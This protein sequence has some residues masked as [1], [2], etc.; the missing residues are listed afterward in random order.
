MKVL[1]II[2]LIFCF[3][4]LCVQAQGFYFY[5]AY[6]PEEYKNARQNWAFAQDTN[7]YLFAGNTE[8]LLKYNGVEWQY[9]HIP[10]TRTVRSLA[11]G[12]DGIIYVGGESEFGFVRPDSLNRISYHR[13]SHDS[14]GPFTEIWSTV[15]F[16]DR[17]YF[18]S[19]E[20]IFMLDKGEITVIRSEARLSQ[21]SKAGDRLFVRLVGTGLAEV[22]GARLV[23]V[24]GGEI[25]SDESFFTIDKLG[26][27]YYIASV[28]Y[29]LTR[30]RG[31]SFEI[32]DT[33]GS[34][35]LS[36][37]DIYRSAEDGNYLWYGTLQGGV[38]K[39]DTAGRITE[40]FTEEAGLYSDLIFTVYRDPAGILWVAT[41]GDINKVLV[42][43][44][45]KILD[46]RS[47]LDGEIYS[48][49]Y[50][51][52]FLY[53]GT[54][55]GLF[56][57]DIQSGHSKFQPIVDAGRISG[58]SYSNDTLFFVSSAGFY[59]IAGGIVKKI[60]V[61]SFRHIVNSAGHMYLAA[62]SQIFQYKP[63]FEEPV[64]LAE[65]PNSIGYLHAEGEEL[66]A[67]HGDHYVSE[68]NVQN[69]DVY[70]YNLN[71]QGITNIYH[72]GSMGGYIYTGTNTGL[73]KYNDAGNTFRKDDTIISGDI[74]SKQVNMFKKCQ[75]EVW[76]RANRRNIRAVSMGDSLWDIEINKFD[77]I[78]DGYEEGVYNILC[79]DSGIFFVSGS[80]IY[81]LEDADWDHENK[82]KTNITGLYVHNDS[83]IYGGFGDPVNEIV[84]PYSD[85]ELRFT[86][87]AAS[88]IS[89]EQNS[90]S[91]K[92]EGFDDKW[93]EWNSETQKDYTNLSEGDYLF[94]VRSRNVYGVPGEEDRISFSISPPW[95]RTWW[96][97][98]LYL[99]TISGLLYTAYTIRVNQLLKVERMR[100]KI[101]SDLHDEVSSTLT[102]ISY[103]A[104]AL[105]RDKD[106][107]RKDHFINL[108]TKS[109]GEAKEKITDIVW[110]I[111]PDNDDFTNFLTKC[112]RYASDLLESKE[113]DYQLNFPKSI[114]GKLNMEYRQHIWM[115]YKEMVTNAV[116]HS[117]A[118]RLDIIMRIEDGK[119]LL[120]VQDNGKG[121]DPENGKKGNGVKNIQRRAHLIQADVKLKSSAEFGT[122]WRMEVKVA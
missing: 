118:D 7:G 77:L 40:K 23:P 33:D 5:S 37:N 79:T 36:E 91:V 1:F 88:Y 102:G 110:S 117:G 62:R 17:V 71:E 61:E 98:L 10:V 35:Y 26:D 50:Q 96:A 55:S 75:G 81:L 84:L 19:N 66:W 65:V 34:R 59:S 48:S 11:V 99:I 60:S 47:G 2:P 103:F 85:N 22:I 111:N 14:L 25:F 4:S 18:Q 115:I 12:T 100:I 72:V 30:L 120:V 49:L 109:A 16:D 89:E 90:Y 68:I 101:A 67:A 39:V 74:N 114:T 87:A 42:N 29:G 57:L 54:S 44:P 43:T 28:N 24:E 113:L 122:R 73:Y 52:G 41:E 58:M 63:G 15:S 106:P 82:F 76:L 93:S 13:L 104:Q 32:L 69:S 3:K 45:I 107:S 70:T 8:G 31:Y 119:L 80:S 121:F 21:L 112:R 64:L 94:R 27:A 78:A 46:D 56:G 92:L 83:L 97:Y 51:D 116:R 38:V 20:A 95:Y 6:L 9:I 105:K 108:I 53:I 86:F